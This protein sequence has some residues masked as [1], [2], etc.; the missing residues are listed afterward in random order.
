MTRR[1][2]GSRWNQG[3]GAFGTP[4]LYA[5]GAFLAGVLVPRLEARFLPGLAAPVSV[6]AAI[7][8][9]SAIASGMLP[10][11]GLVFSLAFVMV[12]FCATAYS[13]RLVSW[14]AGS[15]MMRHSLGVF[16]AAFI[17]ALAALV[18]IDRSGSGKVP[19]LTVSL[20]IALLMASIVVFMLLV[21]TLGMLQIARV[22]PF[23]DRGDGKAPGKGHRHILHRV[24][25][26]VGFALLQRSLE[27]L[28]EEPLAADLRKR[29][30]EAAVALRGHAKQANFAVWV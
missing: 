18:W 12:Q 3:F 30:P 29:S 7:A 9:L 17:Y 16:T 23:A 15:A 27:L 24:H 25:R 13:P 21:D 20:A 2:F 10:L 11:T 14:L 28:D 8:V 19:L 5:A 4:F 1:A 22:L 6:N 26:D